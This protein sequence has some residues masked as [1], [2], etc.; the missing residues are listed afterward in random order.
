MCIR[1]RNYLEVCAAFDKALGTFV[2]RMRQTQKWENTIVVIVS[3]HEARRM[4][5]SPSMSDDRLIFTILNSGLP[6]FT[7]DD[8][9][10]QID[11]FPTIVDAMGLWDSVTWHGFGKSLL[12]EIP[13]FALRHDGSI[14]GNAMSDTAGIAKQQR[15]TELSY[16]WIVADNKRDLLDSLG[17]DSSID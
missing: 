5:L 3:D 16:K 2:A 9:V 12:R 10:G 1:D 15:A 11:V 8:T 14:A 13:G 17:I 7:N 6:G 4:C